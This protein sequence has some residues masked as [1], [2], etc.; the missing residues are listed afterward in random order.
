MKATEHT[1]PMKDD[2]R[3]MSSVQLARLGVQLLN[4]YDLLMQ[5]MTCGETWSPQ[6]DR[7][8]RLPF[9]YWHCPKKC[10]L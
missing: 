6:L 3:H 4:K 1:V 9:G 5:C 2:P 10:N 7:H 8:N